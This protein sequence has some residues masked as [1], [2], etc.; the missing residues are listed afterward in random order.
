LNG[1]RSI[2]ALVA[3]AVAGFA[4]ALGACG[5]S[6]DQQGTSDDLAATLNKHVAFRA[7]AP[8]RPGD[9]S[10]VA[11]PTASN[12]SRIP[13]L[14]RGEV[15]GTQPAIRG[16]SQLPIA[17]WMQWVVNDVAL[18]WQQAFNAAGLQFRTVHY[19]I[20]D[21]PTKTSC[22]QRP[23]VQITMGPFYCPDDETAFLS[24]PYM[25]NRYRRI[26]DAALAIPIAHEVGHH[27][28]KIYHLFDANV[29]VKSIDLELGA[30]CLAG[31]W[32]Q[33]LYRRDL[34]ESGDFKEALDSRSTVGDPVGTS[35]NDPQAHGTS[36]QRVDAFVRG[37]TGG[38]P[39]TCLGT[40]LANLDI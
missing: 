38:V 31:V 6:S 40:S 8:S 15:G 32:A 11:K 20:F 33:S 13:R 10:A 39:E 19:L 36:E 18:Y 1:S 24:V 7:T 3:L 21:R 25:Q 28:E 5:S 17:Q 37:F 30:D 26:G 12:L 16:S 35:P 2:R 23:E 22:R 29:D 9:P 14:T 4:L 34:L 27:V